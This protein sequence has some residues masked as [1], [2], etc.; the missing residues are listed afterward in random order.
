MTKLRTFSILAGLALTFMLQGAASAQDVPI[1]VTLS[2]S[3]AQ[4]QRANGMLTVSI[5]NRSNRVLL[6]PRAYTPLETPDDHLMNNI[7]RVTAEDGRR[8]PFRGRHMRMSLSEPDTFYTKIAPGQTLT[9]ELSLARDYVFESGTF[10]ISYEQPYGEIEL[11]NASDGALLPT[12]RSNELLLS[13]KESL[14]GPRHAPNS[15]SQLTARRSRAEHTHRS[16]DDFVRTTTACRGMSGRQ[17]TR[18]QT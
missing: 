12:A 17:G 10:S 3:I 2:T 18:T 4:S 1:E 14:A 15:D 7:F 6:L 5:T 11:L 8:V 13:I 16:S 9:A